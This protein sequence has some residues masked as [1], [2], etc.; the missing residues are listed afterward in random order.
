M[1]WRN[2]LALAALGAGAAL[3]AGRRRQPPFRFAGKAVLITG[4]SRGLGLVMARMLADQGARLAIMARGLEDIEQ[5]GQEL[6][7]R[8][9]RVLAIQGDVRRPEEARRAV[10]HVVEQFGRID[11]LI[12]NAGVIQFGPLAHMTVDDF[13]DA[14]D[15]HLWGPVHT[16]LAAAAHMRRQGGG[17]IVNIA[18]FAGQVAAPHL[19]PYST[20]KFALVGFSDGL[21]AELAADNIRVTT[22]CPGLMRTGSHLQAMFKGR[23]EQ[24]FAWF[25]IFDSLPL[26]SIDARAA[27]AAILDA[28][29]RGD[30]SL[31]LTLPARV[32]TGASGLFPDLVAAFMEV[33]ARALPSPAGAE[34]NIIRRGWESASPL[35]PSLLTALN[36]RAAAANNNQPQHA[37]PR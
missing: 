20:S 21:R 31:T 7:A 4:G 26:L 24:E 35:A 9:A 23:H 8:G 37:A 33:V 17:R 15:V 27:A 30:P 1:N 19:V 22:V 13:R 18:S 16:S 34:G 28:C 3:A 14:L 12:N 10:E 29:R 32:L 2:T 25:A 6:S 11:V 36:D 5:A